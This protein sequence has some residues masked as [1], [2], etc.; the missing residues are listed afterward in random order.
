MTGR[1]RQHLRHPALPGR[2]SRGGPLPAEGRTVTRKAPVASRQLRDPAEL[3]VGETL[4]D[5]SAGR[6][7]P[8]V[9]PISLKIVLENLLRHED[10]VRVTTEQV[11]SLLAWVARTA[12]ARRGRPEPLAGLPARHQRRPGA[13]RPG[14]HAGRRRRPRRSGAPDQSERAVGTGHR[15][16]RHRRRVRAGRRLRAQRRD[17]VLAQRR[18]VPVPPLGAVDARQLRR[19]PAGDRDHAPGQRRVPGPRGDGRGRLGVPRRLPGHRLAHH[20]G[21]RPRRP[22]LG[23]RRDRGRGGHARPV[24]VDAPAAGGRL[25]PARGA[26]RGRDRDGPGA[27][28]HRE[29]A[30]ARGGREVRRVLRPRR[31]R[32]HGRRPGDDLEHEPGVRF[33]LRVLPDR[34]RDPALPPLHRTARLAGRPGRGLRQ[35]AGPLARPRAVPRYSEFVELDLAAVVP[36]LAGPQPSAAARAA[37]PGK[38]RASAPRCTRH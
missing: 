34:R 7:A 17:R 22:G 8:A 4:P 32:D 2:H 20:D 18:A 25:P 24:A 31:R 38:V 28:H 19:R 37:R 11:Q 1:A 9:L 3:Q 13:R 6:L 14:R 16:L 12:P 35:G 23:D 26:A 5:P 33:D 21:Q 36:S 29:A 30:R 10:G 15:P 27:D